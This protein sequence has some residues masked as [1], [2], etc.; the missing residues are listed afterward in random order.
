MRLVGLLAVVGLVAAVGTS[1]SSDSAPVPAPLPSTSSQ[2]QTTPT[3]TPTPTP[4]PTATPPPMPEAAQGSSRAAAKAF[5]TYYIDL[6]NYAGQTGSVGQLRKASARSCSSCST[7]IKLFS[8]TYERGGYFRTEGW[9][10]ESPFVVPGSR[11]RVWV[12]TSEVH[13]ASV[14]WRTASSASPTFAPQS[15]ILLRLELSYSKQGWR[16]QDM[17]R[18]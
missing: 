17:T 15:T 7:L 4:S 13:E 5:F 10:P 6:V 11:P 16:V 8:S 1:C 12:A 14:R 9:M 2:P 3:P 18:T